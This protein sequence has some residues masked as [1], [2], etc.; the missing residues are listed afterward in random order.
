MLEAERA[1]QS[2]FNQKVEKDKGK[3]Q[4]VKHKFTTDRKDFESGLNEKHNE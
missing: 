1:K 3:R 4:Q 2:E